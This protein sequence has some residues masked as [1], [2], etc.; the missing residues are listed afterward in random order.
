MM[1]SLCYTVQGDILSGFPIISVKTN[2]WV[3]IMTAG[4]LHL[5]SDTLSGIA[6]VHNTQLYKDSYLGPFEGCL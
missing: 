4:S 1:H 3:K 6:C 5:P 2:P